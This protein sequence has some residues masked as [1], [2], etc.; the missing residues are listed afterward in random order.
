[1][2]EVAIENRRDPD[3]PPRR[4]HGLGLENVRSR[5]NALDP[6]ATRFDVSRDADRFRVVLTL[7]AVVN[8]AG[9]SD[10]R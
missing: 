10:A 8:G 7:P 6:R 9:E 4:G 1:M 5:L 2:L 3:A